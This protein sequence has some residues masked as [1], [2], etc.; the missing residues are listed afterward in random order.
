[1]TRRPRR[2]NPWAGDGPTGA[3]GEACVLGSTVTRLA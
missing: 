2:T 3:I 1:M